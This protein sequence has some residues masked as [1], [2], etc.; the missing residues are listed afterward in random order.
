MKTLPRDYIY[1]FKTYSFSQ[2]GENDLQGSKDMPNLVQAGTDGSTFP[3][4]WN[5][6]RN[7]LN[8]FTF[9]KLLSSSISYKN[10]WGPKIGNS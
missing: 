1:I 2:S 7:M 10:T 5:E 3:A 4:H 9:R 6:K 8:Y